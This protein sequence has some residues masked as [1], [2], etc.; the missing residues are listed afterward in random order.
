MGTMMS[1]LGEEMI[2]SFWANGVAAGAASERWGRGM[3]TSAS[4]KVMAVSFA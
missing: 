3:G 2:N 1:R 4:A